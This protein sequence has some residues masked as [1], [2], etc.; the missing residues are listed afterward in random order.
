MSMEPLGHAVQTVAELHAR[1]ELGV[2]KHQRKVEGIAATLGRPAFFYFLLGLIVLWIAGNLLSPVVHLRP[3]DPKPFGWLQGLVGV[4]GLLLTT[5]VLITQ[6]RLGKMAERR[7]LLDLHVNLLSEQKLAK[8]IALVEELRRDLPQVV[9][10]HD[11]QAEAMTRPVDAQAVIATLEKTLAQ[12]VDHALE[13]EVEA[14]II[15]VP[16]DPDA[17]GGDDPIGQ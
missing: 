8:L 7:A 4:L 12:Q 14:E 16:K 1:A 11:P 17:N 6:N 10:R 2:S 5:V 15:G 3:F 13:K 9:N